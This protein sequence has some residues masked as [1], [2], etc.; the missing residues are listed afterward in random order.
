ME[1][2][3][4]PV[5][6]TGNPPATATCATCGT[7][8]D[9]G[10]AADPAFALAA[11][12]DTQWLRPVRLVE[13]PAA[14]P[15]PAAR[16]APPRTAQPPGA[17]ARPPA[18]RVRRWQIALLVAAALVVLAASVIVGAALAGRKAPSGPGTGADG[19]LRSPA[20]VAGLPRIDDPAFAQQV[21]AQV[22]ALGANGFADFVVAG[23]G[24]SVEQPDFVLVAVRAGSAD[25]VRALQAINEGLES[26]G[27][28]VGAGGGTLVVQHDG[29]G[30]RCSTADVQTAPTTCLWQD[31]GTVGVGYSTT[32]DAQRL[33]ELTAAARRALLGR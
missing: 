28:A 11:S 7:P 14:Q 5:C 15:A 17:A 30:F 20:Q 19:R 2:R 8:L 1:Q 12:D 13:P 3:A 22:Q 23:Y 31:A 26:S 9:E 6:G 10:G 32:T 25:R 21:N 16:P 27:A 24:G 18:A 33:S 29:V 4:C